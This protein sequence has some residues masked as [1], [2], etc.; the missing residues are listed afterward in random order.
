MDTKIVDSIANIRLVQGTIRMDLMQ[1]SGS[2][3]EGQ[4]KL[5]KSGELIMTPS[6]FERSLKVLKEAET[7][8][9]KNN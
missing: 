4:L 2:K 8:L 3:I 1:I 6:A 7:N 9:K 5:E